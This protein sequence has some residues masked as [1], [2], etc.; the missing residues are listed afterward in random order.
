MEGLLATTSAVAIAAE[1]IVNN[2]ISDKEISFVEESGFQKV[3]ARFLPA[4]IFCKRVI[5]QFSSG[6]VSGMLNCALVRKLLSLTRCDE[7]LIRDGKV[8]FIFRHLRRSARELQ[9]S[10][11]H[12]SPFYDSSTD[13]GKL[14]VQPT[15]GSF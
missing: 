7:R 13:R 10:N 9:L 15:D 4:S 11:Q 2:S 6:T 1:A 8:G 3:Q 5:S 12:K 14:V